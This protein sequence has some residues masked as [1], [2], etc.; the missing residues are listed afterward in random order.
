MKNLAMD[1]ADMTPREVRELIRKEEITGPTSG[2]C[3]GHVQA[4]LCDPKDEDLAV[5]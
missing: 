3:R 1:Y 2:K 4:N 5:L